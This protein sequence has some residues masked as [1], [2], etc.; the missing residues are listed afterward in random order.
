MQILDLHLRVAALYT[1]LLAAFDS[2]L[3]CDEAMKVKA[4]YFKN[5]YQ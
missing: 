1:I 3:F 5:S 2:I 4:E